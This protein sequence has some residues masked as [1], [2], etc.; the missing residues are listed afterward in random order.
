VK[1]NPMLSGIRK[2]IKQKVYEIV[3]KISR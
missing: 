2:L 3:G 1:T